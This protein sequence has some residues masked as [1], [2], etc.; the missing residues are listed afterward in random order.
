M[1]AGIHTPAASGG[2]SGASVADIR[3]TVLREGNILALTGIAVGLIAGRLAVPWL[4]AFLRSEDDRYAAHFFA[5]AALVLLAT[6]LVA[7]WVPARR[8]MRINPVEALKND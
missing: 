8:A 1:A 5:L 2:G 4:Q 3:R 6:A 7:A